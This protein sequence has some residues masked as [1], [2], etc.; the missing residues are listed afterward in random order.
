MS[1]PWTLT[2]EGYVPGQQG[3]RESLCALGNGHFVTR[4]AATDVEA[5]D[6]H[7]P[8]T[9]LAAGYDRLTTPIGD[10]AVEN[11]SLVNLPNWLPLKVRIEDGAWLH[12]EDTEV[13]DFHQELDLY[14]GILHRHFRYR[15]SRSRVIRW[16]ER[17]IV[18][19]A[20]EHLAALQ[21]TLTAENWSGTLKVHG[22]IDG[23]VTNSGVARYRQ[24][25][26]EHLRTIAT[27]HPSDDVV[28]LHSRFVQARREV[29]LAQRLQVFVDGSEP[30]GGHTTDVEGGHAAQE[31][32]LA[33]TAGQ[34]VTVEKA[35][36]LYNS[37]DQGI[38]E[39]VLEAVQAVER[40]CRFEALAARHCLAWKHLWQECEVDMEAGADENTLM[41]IRLQIFH[42]LQTVS[43]HTVDRDTGVP[44]RGWTGEA[45]RGHIMWDE[46]FIF[47]FLNL[48]IPLLTRAL[49]RYRYRRLPAA[50]RAARQAGY[51]G[52]MYPWQ[53]GS[54]GREESQK[55]HLNPLSGRW[56]P[57]NSDRQR[58]ISA[59]IAYNVWQYYQVTGDR[60]FLYYYG[61][62]MLVEISR[63]WACLATY[64]DALERYQIKGVM[65]PDEYHTAYP[66]KDPDTQGGLDNNA[67]TNV[68]VAWL[69]ARTLDTLDLLPAERRDQ[70]REFLGVAD[71]ELEQWDDISRRLLVPFHDD[72]IISQFQGYEALEEFDWQG[73]R[74][75]YDNI[76]RLDRILESEDDSP[77]RY[78]VSKQADV[79]MLFYLFSAD[80][81]AL[82]FERLGYVLEPD[83]IPKNIAYYLDR[84]SH[85]STLSWV[86]H[87]WV[88]VRA[89]RS[90]A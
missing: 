79:L 20:D 11:E 67:Y 59:D 12:P 39:P 10:T 66:G 54:N 60:E 68:M 15:D 53:S 77:N 33:V 71:A 49:L 85:G 34:P 62:E 16:H 63:F 72:G 21:V 24:L 44:A 40:A 55:L 42:L 82:V 47:P 48:R 3:L 2:Y 83:A 70:L 51:T 87:A 57:D 78:K 88:L 8:G 36:A 81:L 38:S 26:G 22:A 28:L 14:R 7:Y 29:A 9:Y 18:S 80:E 17:R 5:G 64:D 90:R 35:V 61:A 75:R 6:I 23:R 1:D 41:K 74:Q 73:Y 46:L 37:R 31:L 19:M 27:D 84:T 43:Y 56:I 32:T 50:R 65:G 89:D 13:L 45:Y 30:G 86:V 52:A 58:H 69:M 76:Q 4:A 25:E